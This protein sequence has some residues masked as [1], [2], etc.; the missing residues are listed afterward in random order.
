MRGFVMAAALLALAACDE[1]PTAPTRQD[2]A[3]RWFV[4]SLEPRN[5]AP[6]SSG[7]T[8]LAIEFTDDRIS[9]Q[10][11]CNTCTGGYTLTGGTIAMPLLACTRRACPQGSLE[12]PLLDLISTADTAGVVAGT[13]LII[14]GRNGRI[15]LR[16]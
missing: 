7:S 9:V 4:A 3:G 1:T 15:V 13:T 2:L 14:E 11:D 5:A 16:R 12:G 6:I 10:G 8:V